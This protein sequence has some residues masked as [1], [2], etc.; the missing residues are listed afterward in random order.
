VLAKAMLSYAA[1]ELMGEG[2]VPC[3]G[4]VRADNVASLR[5]ARAV[6]YREHFQWF[7]CR[8]RVRG[9]PL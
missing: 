7:S 9:E 4:G 1:R 3:Y 2:V 6:G 8:G 5:T